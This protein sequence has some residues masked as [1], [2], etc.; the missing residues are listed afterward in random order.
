[1]AGKIVS[2]P[3]LNLEPAKQ[4]SAQLMV[5]SAN[6]HHLKNVQSPADP[7][8]SS[9]LGPVLLRNMVAIHVL[10]IYLK[11]EIVKLKNAQFTAR[12]LSGRPTDPAHKLVDWEH[13][14]ALEAAFHP[15]TEGMTALV[16]LSNRAPARLRNAQ[17]MAR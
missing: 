6:G 4:K 5:K 1:M 2:A 7:E 15:S 12:L 9:E 14:S 3:F 13:R 8:L 17:L 11:P 10:Q 16:K